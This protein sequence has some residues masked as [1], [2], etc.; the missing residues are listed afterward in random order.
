MDGKEVDNVESRAA[1][2]RRRRRRKRSR[3][4]YERGGDGDDGGEVGVYEVF[5]GEMKILERRHGRKGQKREVTL[6]TGTG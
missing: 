3:F 5:R 4:Y 6:E 2:A 1:G